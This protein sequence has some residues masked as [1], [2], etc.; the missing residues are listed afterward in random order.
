MD[1]PES[2]LA[3]SKSR[4]AHNDIAKSTGAEV[5]NALGG[6]NA[7]DLRASFRRA[8]A[9]STPPRTLYCNYRPGVYSNLIFGVPLVDLGLNDDEVPKV[10]RMCIDEVEKRGL[11]INK[12]YSVRLLSRHVFGS[13]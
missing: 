2:E 7:S 3:C 6:R 12:I 11:H 9:Y 10:M 1:L 5:V 13:R 8:I 4:A